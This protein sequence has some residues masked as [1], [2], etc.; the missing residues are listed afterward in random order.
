ME[1][2]S[3]MKGSLSP[4][5]VQETTALRMRWLLTLPSF[6]LSIALFLAV[7][8][9]RAI[10]QIPNDSFSANR[11]APAPG[12]GNFVMVDGALVTGHVTPSV[13][14][15]I[16]YAHRP[17][18]IFTATCNE[19]DPDD[20]QVDESEKDIVSYQLTFSPMATISLWQQ[21]PVS[22]HQ[23]EHLDLAPRGVAIEERVARAPL[24]RDVE[25]QR[26]QQLAEQGLE[27]AAANR[28]GRLQ[29]GSRRRRAGVHESKCS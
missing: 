20:C 8:A 9:P 25:P 29:T 10:A 2:G 3:P 1:Y 26:A 28:M 6:G 14:L 18:V 5:S 7:F 21:R 11:F 17:F 13:G 12:P 19:G 15:F 27:V 22:A 16:D 24:I 23:V 4:T